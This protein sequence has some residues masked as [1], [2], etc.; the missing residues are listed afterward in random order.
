MRAITDP[1]QNVT[2]GVKYL[3]WLEKQWA[4]RIADST[5]RLKFVLAS[6]NAGL[7]HIVDAQRLADKHGDDP[8]KWDDVAYWLLQLAKQEYHADPVVR[9]GYCRGYEPVT[10]VALIL[11]RFD[12]YRQFVTPTV[13]DAGLGPARVAR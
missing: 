4:S 5:E 13:A 8:E 9:Y 6:Y 2:G 7:G 11:E 10:Y 12:H 3:R 1:A